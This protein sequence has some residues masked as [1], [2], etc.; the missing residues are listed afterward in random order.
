VLV[1][2]E[3]LLFGG[4]VFSILLNINY[5]FRNKELSRLYLQMCNTYNKKCELEVDETQEHVTFNSE[6]GARI[7]RRLGE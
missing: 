5:Y 2:L 4:L 6:S 1:V 3:M 7:K